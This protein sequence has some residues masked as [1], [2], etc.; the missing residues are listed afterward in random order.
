MFGWLL[1]G[2]RKSLLS[3]STAG[4][5]RVEQLCAAF[6]S[7]EFRQLSENRN[8]CISL[9]REFYVGK[10]QH[11]SVLETVQTLQIFSELIGR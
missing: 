8:S 11:H 5:L 3:F 10:S 7:R 9:I 6:L 1:M 4:A 2:H